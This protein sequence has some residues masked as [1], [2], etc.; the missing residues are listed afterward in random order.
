[1]QKVPYQYG[2]NA[3]YYTHKVLKRNILELSQKY[4][5]L[6]ISSIGKSIKNRK[7]YILKYG[8]GP[9]KIFV[10]G[11]THACEWIT[12]PILM[13]W[14]EEICHLYMCKETAYSKRIEELFERSTIHVLP[15]LNPDGIELQIKGITAHYPGYEKLI[16]WNNGS[17]DFSKWKA[18]IRGVD[19][20][21]NFNAQW[22]ASKKI[23]K[24]EGIEGPWLEQYGGEYAESEPETAAIANYT[25]Q[26]DFDMV[27]SYHTQGQEIYWC[28]DNFEID[29]AKR[30]GTQLAKAS[31]YA[32]GVP[33]R[34]AAYA[35]YK[36]WFIKEF[37]RPGYT[38]E[39]GLGENPLPMTQFDQIYTENFELL[40]IAAWGE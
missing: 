5:F 9:R 36:D 1:M 32:L 23:G 12:V 24:E 7:I 33:D 37:K 17:D 25:R 34:N 16:Q 11:G 4:K 19:L 2:H 20:N 3:I 10:C 15:M 35:G 26:E 21:R 39:C 31:G 8:K 18:N 6:E 13:K 22:E 28:Y 29:G 30:L 27:L 40:L 38:I 14:V